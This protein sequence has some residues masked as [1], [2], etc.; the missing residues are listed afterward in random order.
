MSDAARL[1]HDVA[2]YLTRAARNLSA[3]PIAPALAQMLGRDL[4]EAPG[5]GRPSARFAELARVLDAKSAAQVRA[6]FAE[7]DALEVEVRERR[8]PAMRMAARVALDISA[9]IVKGTEGATPS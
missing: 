2:K 5:G 4:Y 6:L 9:I 8:E 7:L 3:A 1:R